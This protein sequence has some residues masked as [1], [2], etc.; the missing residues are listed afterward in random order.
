[1]EIIGRL[2]ERKIREALE[3]GAFKDLQGKGK[4][5]QLTDDSGVPAELRMAYKILKNANCLPEELELRKEMLRLEDLLR[6]C[7]EEGQRRIHR[8]KLTLARLRL[9]MALERQGRRL[10]PQYEEQA[11]LKLIKG[12]SLDE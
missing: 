12:R 5:L 8:E 2:A 9:E 4:P 6:C 7:E 3:D 1:M 10:P 11:W